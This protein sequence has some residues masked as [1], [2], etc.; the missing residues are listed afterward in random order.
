MVFSVPGGLTGLIEE[1][2]AHQ[3]LS[4]GQLNFDITQPTIWTLVLGAVFTNFITYGS[5]QTMIQRYVTASSTKEA[6]KSMWL[7]AWMVVPATKIGRAS[8][9]ERVCQYV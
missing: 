9:R 5:D 1:A 4:L 8:C 2:N 6:K 3:K 7:N